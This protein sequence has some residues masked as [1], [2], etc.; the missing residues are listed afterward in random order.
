M[1]LSIRWSPPEIEKK[2]V[3]PCQEVAFFLYACVISF[4]CQGPLGVSA[5]FKFSFLFFIR[6]KFFYLFIRSLQVQCG[7]PAS[8]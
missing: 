1:M 8:F 5:N 2:P 4:S 3:S 7:K 6:F